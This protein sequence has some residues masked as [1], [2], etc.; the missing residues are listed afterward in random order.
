MPSSGGATAYCA[1]VGNLFNS[2]QS[3]L[4]FSP[5]PTNQFRLPGWQGWMPGSELTGGRSPS[6]VHFVIAPAASFAATADPAIFAASTIGDPT[7]WCS[8]EVLGVRG[9]QNGELVST[10]QP[11]YFCRTRAN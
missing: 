11:I 10:R 9:T 1:P 3:S 5:S 6:P 8:T 7:T 4:A 2:N